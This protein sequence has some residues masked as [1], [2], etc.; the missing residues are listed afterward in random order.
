MFRKKPATVQSEP[1]NLDAVIK[2][3]DHIENSLRWLIEQNNTK[4]LTQPTAEKI[5]YTNAIPPRR[6]MKVV[7]GHKRWTQNDL[8]LLIELDSKGLSGDSIAQ[9]MG[10][11][12]RAVH[13]KLSNLKLNK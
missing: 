5:E 11:T 12:R 10:R 6:K 4:R 9:A 7:N 3:L 1:T 8:L 2:R 13:S